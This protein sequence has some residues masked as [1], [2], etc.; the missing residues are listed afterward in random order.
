MVLLLKKRMHGTQDETAEAG[1]C[2]YNRQRKPISRLV[3][4][5]LLYVKFFA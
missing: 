3:N 5:A 4:M 2:L 1:V